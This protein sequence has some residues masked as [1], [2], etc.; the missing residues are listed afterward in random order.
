MR[1]SFLLIILIFCFTTNVHS[2]EE[3]RVSEIS[4]ELNFSNPKVS[5]SDILFSQFG[6][7]ATVITEYDIKKSGASDVQELL[8]KVPGLSIKQSGG[9]GGVVSIFSRGSE[10]DHNLVIIDGVKINE[11][12]GYYDF[13]RLSINN[14]EQIEVL[15]GP[16]AALY[17]PGAMGSVISIR[18]K[19]YNKKNT[20][21]FSTALGLGESPSRGLQSNGG[22]YFI[23]EQGISIS[24]VSYTHL[25]LPTTEAV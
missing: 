12:G 16:Q 22:S 11:I 6:G 9:R 17:G 5:N 4:N 23:N 20:I 21:A 14:I 19:K 1:T 2:K 7:S 10:S 13:S 24:A 25:T 15:R 3:S 8:R 18:T